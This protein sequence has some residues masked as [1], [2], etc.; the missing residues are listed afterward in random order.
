MEW[1]VST[2]ICAPG[3]QNKCEQDG[4]QSHGLWHLTFELSRPWQG[5]LADQGNIVLG[6][7]RPGCLGGAGRL[8][9][10]V[11]LHRLFRR[12][13]AASA[14]AARKLTKAEHATAM[15]FASS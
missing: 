13:P 7:G 9:R 6:P 15:Y 11:R 4:E 14:F 5:A 3:S 2:K 8:E 12:M 10:R 1:V